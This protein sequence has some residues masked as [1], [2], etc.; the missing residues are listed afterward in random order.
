ML[1]RAAAVPLRTHETSQ[2]EA[3]HAALAPG[4]VLLGDRAFCSYAHLAVLAQRGLH[5][6]FRLHQRQLVDFRPGRGHVPPGRSANPEDLPRSR[7]VRALGGE[8]QV[9][10]WFK[11]KRRPEWLTPAQF[12]A[13]P[14]ELGVRELRYRVE[15]S[16]FRTRSVVLATTLLDAEAYPASALAELYLCRWQVEGDLKHLKITMNMDVLRSESVEGVLK[17]LAVFCLAYNLVRSVM[18][19]SAAAQGVAAERI[20]LVDA[21]RWLIGVEDAPATALHVNPARPG[22]SE[23][24]VVKRRPKQYRLMNRP[25]DELRKMLLAQG[26]AA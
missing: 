5:G 16:G 13:L 3:V 15:A 9:V 11:P 23:P 12:A 1:L 14:A 4:D 10:V 20:S 8:D 6:V 17:E 22:R 2:L 21:V 24:R 25:R 7:W 26:D 19:E 18:A